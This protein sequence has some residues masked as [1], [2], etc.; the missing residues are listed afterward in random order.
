MDEPQ[1]RLGEGSWPTVKKESVIRLVWRVQGARGGLASNW[2]SQ[3]K[4]NYW[5]KF[6]LRMAHL[7]EKGTR[8]SSYEC[9]KR[10]DVQ[11]CY[12]GKKFDAQQKPKT[13]LPEQS[14]CCTYYDQFTHCSVRSKSDLAPGGPKKLQRYRAWSLRDPKTR[15]HRVGNLILPTL[16]M[17]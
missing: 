9:W 16:F 6:R 11:S 15:L 10:E 7:M 17:R 13:V 1:S 14:L 4:I 2:T 5:A 12:W 8:N 3:V